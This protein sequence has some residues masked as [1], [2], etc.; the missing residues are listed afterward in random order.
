LGRCTLDRSRSGCCSLQREEEA[1]V[2][3]DS[4]YHPN[5]A[6][7]QPVVSAAAVEGG[8]GAKGVT[9]TE[10]GEGATKTQE[11][12]QAAALKGSRSG[13]YCWKGSDY[14]QADNDGY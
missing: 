11:G 9:K 7:T 1:Y 5:K 14:R 2:S 10:G 6:V 12:A 4:T 3:Q 13:V 8:E